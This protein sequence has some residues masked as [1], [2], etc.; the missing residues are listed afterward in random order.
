MDHSEF[1]LAFAYEVVQ[2]L[3][4]STPQDFETLLLFSLIIKKQKHR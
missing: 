3:C 1:L 4:Q 2:Y